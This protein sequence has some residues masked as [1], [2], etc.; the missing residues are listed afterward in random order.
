MTSRFFPLLFGC[1]A[2]PVLAADDRSIVFETLT[3]STEFHAEGA[4]IGDFDRDGANDVV[5][6]PFIY[7]G[8]DF[9]SSTKIYDGPRFDVRSYSKNFLCYVHDISGDGFDDVV[10]MGFPGEEGYWFENPKGELKAGRAGLWK[11]CVAVQGLDNE[12]PTFSDVT[13]DGKPEIV[14]CVQERFGYAEPNWQDPTQPW[15]FTPVSP[16]IP[17]MGRF[18]HGLGLG[19]VNKDGRT[20]FLWKD[21]WWEQPADPRTQP[22]WTRHDFKFGGG[23]AQMFAYDFDGDGDNDVLTSLAAHGFGLSWFENLDGSGT[24]GR[25]TSSSATTSK[26]VPSRVAFSQHHAV[27]MADFDGDGVMDFV[28]GKRWFA[29][30]GGDPGAWSRASSTGFA[31]SAKAARAPSRSSRISSTTTRASAPR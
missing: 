8:P 12:S 9:K 28:T 23:G 31:R 18:T 14:C 11:K 30:N 15:R 2:V 25:T 26:P 4:A 20:D 3:L 22:E 21:G 1:L 5:S 10:V 16:P 24:P 29:H 6:G 7:F 19:D 13:G 17:G 27:D